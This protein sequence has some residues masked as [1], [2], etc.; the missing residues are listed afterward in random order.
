MF[1]SFFL[2]GFEGSTGYNRHGRWFDQVAATGHDGTVERDYRDL[3]ALGIHAAR[4]TVRWPLVDRGGRYDFSSLAPFV[5]A[6]RRSRVEVI[7]DL[8]HYGYPCDVDLWSDRFPE[9]FADYCAA[10]ARY[11]APPLAEEGVAR[12]IEA[13]VLAR[14]ADARTASDRLI[15]DAA[16]RRDAEMA[17]GEPVSA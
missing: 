2:A 16:A 7:W 4:E 5:E 8:F 10:V 12:M 11:I 13:L 14:P 3:A 1:R 6:A 15:A 17:V 9:R